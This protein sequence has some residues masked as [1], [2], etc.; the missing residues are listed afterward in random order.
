MINS[1]ADYYNNDRHQ[2]DR[3]KMTPAEFE[4]YLNSAVR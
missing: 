1:Y 4:K 3:M 2:W